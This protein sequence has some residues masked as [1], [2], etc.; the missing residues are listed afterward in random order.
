MEKI[1]KFCWSDEIE[2]LSYYSGNEEK[3]STSP[4]LEILGGQVSLHFIT[5][6]DDLLPHILYSDFHEQIGEI[7]IEWKI[8][9]LNSNEDKNIEKKG[10]NKFRNGMLFDCG[11]ILKSSSITNS[12]YLFENRIRVKLET[13]VIDFI[14]TEHLPKVTISV[15][16]V[17][18]Y[19]F[20]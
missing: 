14:M 10:K 1:E 11:N 7:E 3:E 12:D 16:N 18:K 19:Y 15:I 5:V 13:K 4:V 17:D 2:F 8:I 20:V 6:F 9:L